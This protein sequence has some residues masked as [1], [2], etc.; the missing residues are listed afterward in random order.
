MAEPQEAGSTPDSQIPEAPDLSDWD[1]TPAKG[2]LDPSL[3][4]QA[5]EFWQRGREKVAN[6]NQ[7][8]AEFFNS[9][10]IR[11][12]ISHA[13][14][15]VAGHVPTPEQVR[16]IA[17][18]SSN[19]LSNVRVL[20]QPL[21]DLVVG[22]I[23]GAGAK[24]VAK[25]GFAIAGVGGLPVAAGVGAV[26]GGAGAV[27]REYLKQRGEG[28]TIEE[29][30]TVTGIRAKLKNEFRRIQA[31]DK[32]RLRNAAIRGV[33]FGAV[34]GVVGGV[35]AD[36]LS[37]ELAKVQWPEIQGPQ[38][39]HQVGAEPTAT[40]TESLTPT[41]TG[42]PVPAE[43]TAAAGAPAPTETPTPTPTETA[44]PTPVTTPEATATP[45]PQAETPPSAPPPPEAP[46]QPPAEA[47]EAMKTPPDKVAVPE[48][49][50]ETFQI[51]A[52]SNPWVEVDKYL[53]ENLDRN[54]TNQEIRQ[55]VTRLL[56]EN[57]ITDATKIPA[58][59]E[60]QIGSVKEYL[61]QILSE[62]PQITAELAT[63]PEAISLPS[64]SNPWSETSEYLE[65]VLGR[66]PS[67]A[68]ILK[69]T[70]E[71]CRQSNISV[72]AWNIAGANLD[73]Q[74]PPGFRLNFNQ[75]AKNVISSL[76]K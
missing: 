33:V 69:V 56:T 3:K 59:S 45:L 4:Q 72:P 19:R 6:I 43:T 73:T 1:L 61:G 13:Y 28:I 57:S 24:E 20:G 58:G 62:Q 46:A 7:R 51:P 67:N 18:S 38:I 41:P 5:G 36:K 65:D 27:V 75:S 39:N 37:E 21:L 29:D 70:Q 10:Q 32:T 11:E 22:G 35:I 26:A 23:A 64:G 47:Q 34:G 50:Q 42:T 63:A 74:L 53:I 30:T 2:P 55:A 71:V 44:T 54:P 49:A 48:T 9:I 40:P 76:V 17:N 52:G 12:G 25:F 14:E 8:S 15:Q 68:E 16:G 31:A 60:L 66:K